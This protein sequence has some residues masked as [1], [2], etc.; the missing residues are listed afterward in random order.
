M[1]GTSWINF[2]RRIPENVQD[3]LA[4]TVTTGGEIIV[5]RLVKLDPEFVVLRGRM[6]GSLDPGRLVVLPYGQLVTVAFT[7]R[8]SDADA[9]AIFGAATPGAAPIALSPAGE[10]SGDV[11]GELAAEDADADGEEANGSAA[12]P[13]MPSK[14]ILLAKLRARLAEGNNPPGK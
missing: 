7:R 3:T 2:F 6:A 11:P 9:E 14:S 12:K 8:M 1:Q 5:Q 13:A 10:G 4:L